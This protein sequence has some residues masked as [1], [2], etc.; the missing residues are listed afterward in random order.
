MF[1]YYIKNYY[2]EAFDVTVF[3]ACRQST[4]DTSQLWNIT[5]IWSMSCVM[6]LVESESRDTQHNHMSFCYMLL[7]SHNIWRKSAKITDNWWRAEDS[8][9]STADCHAS[10]KRLQWDHVSIVQPL[11]GKC[12]LW[13]PCEFKHVCK[14]RMSQIL[15]II[16]NKNHNFLS[17]NQTF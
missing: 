16:A 17:N 11:S 7:H 8:Y 10:C 15:A 2:I 12:A 9:V 14:H 3:L 13:V 6:W 1:K 4:P 5:I